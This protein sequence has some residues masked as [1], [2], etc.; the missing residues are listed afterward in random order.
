MESRPMSPARRQDL[1]VF[2]ASSTIPFAMPASAPA[3]QQGIS[4]PAQQNTAMPIKAEAYK[5]VWEV[6]DT[7]AR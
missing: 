7:P 1:P 4:A 2:T 3:P 6:P 5:D